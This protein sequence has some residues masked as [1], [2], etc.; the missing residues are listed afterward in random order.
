VLEDTPGNHQIDAP[1]TQLEVGQ[2]S[3]RQIQI[4]IGDR[5]V[6]IHNIDS[7]QASGFATEF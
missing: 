5:P 1:G 2:I 3:H 4:T 7:H 6:K